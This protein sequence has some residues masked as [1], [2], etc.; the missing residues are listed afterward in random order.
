[1]SNADDDADAMMQMRCKL[2]LETLISMFHRYNDGLCYFHFFV[3]G[4]REGGTGSPAALNRLPSTNP[5]ERRAGM[6][7]VLTATFTG[8]IA[9]ASLGL[10]S[11]VD[12]AADGGGGR[13][14]SKKK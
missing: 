11:A 8:E 10:F 6:A 7:P 13:S 2:C 4:G 3:G 1:M 12:G 9:L 14:C 5:E